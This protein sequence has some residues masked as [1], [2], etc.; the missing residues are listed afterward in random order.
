MSR[1]NPTR[2]SF[3]LCYV[4]DRNALSSIPVDARLLLLEKIKAAARAGVDWIQIRERDLSGRELAALTE[5]ATC[6]APAPCR[7]LVNDRLD[8]ACAVRA[9]GVHLGEQSIS[10]ADAIRFLE[11][12]DVPRPFLVGA[13]THSL[14][15]ARAAADSGADYVLFGPVFSTPSKAGYGAPQGIE[16]LTEVCRSVLIPVLAIGGITPRNAPACARAG[17]AGV[18]AIRIFQDSADLSTVV[19]QLR[20]L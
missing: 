8:V 1:P 18:A 16:R 11:K 4:T 6:A 20:Q 17:A 5:E 2:S 12:R 15:A 7:V 14:G 9:S 13:S 3:R 10:V 19:R